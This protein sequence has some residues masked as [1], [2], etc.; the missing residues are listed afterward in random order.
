MTSH[1]FI[2]KW[3]YSGENMI[4]NECLE[5]KW[6]KSHHFDKLL[7][8]SRNISNK[9]HQVLWGRDEWQFPQRKHTDEQRHIKTWYISPTHINAN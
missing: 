7:A 6:E 3:I 4:I 2:I 9:P 5:Y 8:N 1:L